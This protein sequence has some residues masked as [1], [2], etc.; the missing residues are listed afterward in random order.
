MYRASACVCQY[1]WSR[2]WL[3]T[4]YLW[5]P[6]AAA[7]AGIMPTNLDPGDSTR[8]GSSRHHECQKRLE[9][10]GHKEH[11]LGRE[12]T[13]ATRDSPHRTRERRF[14]VPSA[15]S[16]RFARTPCAGSNRTTC[17][18]PKRNRNQNSNR[19]RNRE[20]E[21]EKTL[22]QEKPKGRGPGASRCGER[23]TRYEK[24]NPRYETRDTRQETRD[25]AEGLERRTP[26][27]QKVITTDAA[28]D[29]ARGPWGH[30]RPAR[31][32][33]RSEAPIVQDNK[34]GALAARVAGLAL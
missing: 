24:R 3:V 33:A 8:R 11:E 22:D 7:L 18:R 14:L 13:I 5:L 12:L 15:L 25:T 27:L 23:P 10:E 1:Q 30:T 32:C 6:A 29:W 28:R 2:L 17:S 31:A 20:S 4:R 16:A 34:A 9:H 21:P 26:E 19:K